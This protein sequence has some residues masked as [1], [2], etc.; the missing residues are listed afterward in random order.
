M[1]VD[2]EAIA[3][4]P[5]RSPL[6]KLPRGER[7]HVTPPTA[8]HVLA[9]HGRPADEYRLPL[10]V[11]EATGMR[12]GEL[13]V[14]GWDDVDE[15]RGRWRTGHKTESSPRWVAPPPAVFATWPACWAWG[16]WQR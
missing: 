15:P 3:P 13:E 10:V 5:A 12:V 14:L 9:A 7:R 6:V 1:V 8:A 11:L 4:N 2:A 16:N